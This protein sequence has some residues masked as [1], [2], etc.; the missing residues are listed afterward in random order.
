MKKILKGMLLGIVLTVVLMCT[1]VIG[2]SAANSNDK[3]IGAWGTA[4]TEIGIYG[5]SNITAYVG[6]VTAR[7]VITPTASGSKLRLRFHG[8]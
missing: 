8:S 1:A 4:P 5:Y 2:A 6:N 7:T 3:W